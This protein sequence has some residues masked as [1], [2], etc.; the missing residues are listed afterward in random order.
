MATENILIDLR[1]A[2]YA[3]FVAK[4][5]AGAWTYGNSF[6]IE[7]TWKPWE[8]L[9]DFDENHPTGKVY[10][11]GMSPFDQVKESRTNL[12]ILDTCIQIGFQRKIA[13][14]NDVAELDSYAKFA[15][16]LAEACRLEIDYDGGP[17]AL[18]FADLEGIAWSRT[19]FLKD[20]DG[21]PFSFTMLRKQLFF[22]AYF[23]VY[24]KIPLEGYS[25]TTTTT[26]TTTT[27]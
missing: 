18:G 11:I 14:I 10:I 3:R 16:E 1:D 9:T 27:T 23:T 21:V 12:T 6:T 15:M 22:E 20:P 5:Q 24:Y 2:I 8:E 7:K 17:T 19:D 4:Q 26:T 13:D 25:L